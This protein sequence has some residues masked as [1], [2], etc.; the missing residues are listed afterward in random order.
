MCKLVHRCLQFRFKFKF[1]DKIIKKFSIKLDRHGRK[2]L[3]HQGSKLWTFMSNDLKIR[4]ILL[5][6]RSIL[7]TFRSKN[8]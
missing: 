3:A 2:H 1:Q 8:N 5:G 4:L 7:E 6:T